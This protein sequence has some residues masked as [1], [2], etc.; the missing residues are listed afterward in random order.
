MNAYQKSQYL[1]AELP[2]SMLMSNWAWLDLCATRRDF[3]GVWTVRV[4]NERFGD[5]TPAKWYRPRAFGKT[6]MAVEGEPR[7]KFAPWELELIEWLN[8]H[9]KKRIF[10]T[11]E[12]VFYFEDPK[13]AMLFKL[14]WA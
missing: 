1:V 14:T 3:K 10:V 4:S 7:A 13:E 12:D 9:V 8:T 11:R 6:Q 5:Y 2:K